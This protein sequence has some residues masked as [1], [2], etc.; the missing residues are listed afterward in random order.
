M[1]TDIPVMPAMAPCTI[2][3]PSTLQ[4]TLSAA[5]AGIERIWYDGSMYRTSTS[6]CWWFSIHILACSL[7]NT[8]MSGSRLFPE[9]S[10][11]RFK[12][13]K[14]SCP[15]PSATTS[16]QCPFCLMTSW[17]CL[18][19][20]S[21]WNGDS[22]MRQTSTSLV[23]RVANIDTNPHSRPI[24]FTIAIPCMESSASMTAHWITRTASCTAVSNPNDLSM[25]GTSLSMVLGT[26]HTAIG[27]L[28]RAASFEMRLAPLCVPSPPIT[29]TWLT[30]SSMSFSMILSKSCPPRD[31]PRIVPPRRW[32][33]RTLSLVI[34][35]HSR[36]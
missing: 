19:R 24:S 35:F 32:M 28:R 8:P 17:Q 23:A 7:R 5:V 31:D 11:P 2:A 29:Y 13:L 36:V 26:P 22:G 21:S 20:R 6:L 18:K 4:Y 9:G 3:V 34:S 33:L 25:K 12:S 16:T 15:A 30:P 14:W 27:I 1:P 10:M